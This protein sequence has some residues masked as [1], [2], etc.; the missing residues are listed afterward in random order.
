MV[1]AVIIFMFVSG[2]GITAF[3][4][5]G[6]F[7]LSSVIIVSIAAGLFTTFKVDTNHAAWIG[8][9]ALFGIGCGLGMQVSFTV[10]Q[11]SLPMVDTPIA[12]TLMSFSMM[13]GGAIWAAVA[14]NIFANVLTHNLVSS[15]PN[16][17]PDLVRLTGATELKN[18]IDPQFLPQV[19]V[20]Y[21]NA[22]TKTWDL[23]VALAVVA[24]VGVAAIDWRISVKGKEISPGGATAA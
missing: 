3:G 6:P 20:A 8:Y 13:L 9:Q 21:N 1:I 12:T 18:V 14:Q 17:S 2:G 16:V 24:I 5:Y 23:A 19:L 7:M 15:V 22:L 11:A 10:V 4:Y